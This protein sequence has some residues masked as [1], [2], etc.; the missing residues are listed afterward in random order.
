MTRGLTGG[1]LCGAIR[2]RLA[3]APTGI[4]TCHCTMCRKSAGGAFQLYGSI[5]QS[6]IDWEKGAP[7]K[8]ATSAHARRWFCAD[9]GSPLVFEIVNREQVGITIP[10]L[11]DPAPFPPEAHDGAESWLP[12]LHMDDGLPRRRTEDDPEIAEAIAKA[13]QP[14]P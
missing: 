3:S 9:C 7:K 10:S 13:G 12:W 6:D 8:R 4:S 2:Y 14:R 11:D 1:C 5:D